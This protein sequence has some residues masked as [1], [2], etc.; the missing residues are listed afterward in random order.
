[1][2][3]GVAASSPNDDVERHAAAGGG[4]RVTNTRARTAVTTVAVTRTSAVVVRQRGTGSATVVDGGTGTQ[5]SESGEGRIRTGDT[6]VFSRVLYQLSYLAAVPESSV[7][8][9][10]ASREDAKHLKMEIGKPKRIH[11]VEPL[12]SPVPPPDEKRA[13][14]PEPL[15]PAKTE[16]C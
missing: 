3:H 5:G 12:K 13:P 16:R 9:R 8:G 15:V 1:V 11:R 2:A 4:G 14:A 10:L 7:G 6:T